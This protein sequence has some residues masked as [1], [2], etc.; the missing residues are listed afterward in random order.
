MQDSLWPLKSNYNH[1]NYVLKNIPVR[2]DK[3]RSRGFTMAMDKGL[4]FGKPR[5]LLTAALILLT[6]LN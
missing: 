1:M 3:P 6:L 4:S 2:T 5:I